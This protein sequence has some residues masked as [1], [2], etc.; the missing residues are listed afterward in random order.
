MIERL[1]TRLEAG[2]TMAYEQ[3][4]EHAIPIATRP[5]ISADPVILETIR[6]LE[7]PMDEIIDFASQ[8]HG[9]EPE[10]L[11]SMSLSFQTPQNQPVLG[12]CNTYPEIHANKIHYPNIKIMTKGIRLPQANR[13]L[14][15]EIRHIFQPDTLS[16][17]HVDQILRRFQLGLEV[18][19]V[20]IG[21][22]SSGE[23]ADNIKDAGALAVAAL[24]TASLAHPR[25]V[26]PLAW[27]TE[28]DEWDATAFS[29][30]NRRF[31]PLKA[32]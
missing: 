9:I 27:M 16:S 6:G 30:R 8:E 20:G 29:M 24:G 19:A 26:S 7:I 10:T 22:W 4:R 1:P 23:A 25:L 13:T 5:R 28:R 11:Q 31:R 15:H 18:A 32:A 17:Y 3:S 12:S 2:A 21:V 14:R